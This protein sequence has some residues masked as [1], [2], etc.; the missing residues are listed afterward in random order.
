MKYDFNISK[1]ILWL[2][3]S[4]LRKPKQI[5]WLNALLQPIGYIH[6]RFYSFKQRVDIELR[7]SPQVRIL[8]GYLNERFDKDYN[9]IDIV[10]TGQISQTYIFLESENAPLYL[11]VFLSIGDNYDFIVRLPVDLIAYETGIKAI[12]NKFKLP[13]K[14]YDIQ[15]F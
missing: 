6:T 12:L 11:P 1:W 10:D 7:V 9:R 3:P 14:R 8:R 2:L 4:V 5:A 15:Y 13:S